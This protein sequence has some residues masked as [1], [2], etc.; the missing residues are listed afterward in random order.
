LEGKRE[1]LQTE[2]ERIVTEKN[3]DFSNGWLKAKEDPYI[4]LLF[5]TALSP[6]HP[7]DFEGLVKTT[8]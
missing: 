4:L 7:W 2:R 1:T 8:T 6:R 5:L 3:E